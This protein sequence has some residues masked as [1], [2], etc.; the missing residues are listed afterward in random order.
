[1]ETIYKELIINSI[2]LG[3]VLG[4][5]YIVLLFINI[6]FVDRIKISIVMAL[7]SIVCSGLFSVLTIYVLL[8]FILIDLIIEHKKSLEED[9]LRTTLEVLESIDKL[10]KLIER[11]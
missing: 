2:L 1:M 5:I 8:H 11:K 7:I 10:K 6:T 4:C 3:G 9:R